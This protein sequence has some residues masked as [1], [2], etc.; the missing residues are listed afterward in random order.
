MLQNIAFNQKAFYTPS[1]HKARM[2]I[3]VLLIATFH[4]ISCVKVHTDDY[5]EGYLYSQTEDGLVAL[6]NA[7]AE[8]LSEDGEL[9]ET[10]TVP[11]GRQNNFLSIPLQE[12]WLNSPVSLRIGGPNNASILWQG[13]APSTNAMWLPGALFAIEDS[14][15]YT[16]LSSFAE[17]T[18]TEITGNIHL[19]GEPYF[20]EEWT[21]V[22]ISLTDNE[23][24]TYTVY[25]FSQL[26]TGLISTN[27]E[28][29][30]DWFFAWNLPAE[31][32]TLSITTDQGHEKRL[33]YFPNEGDILSALYVTLPTEEP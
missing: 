29:K 28:Q 15:L 18:D 13:T 20:P 3:Y 1:T 16:F 7:E 11:S 33:Q 12:D 21:G 32:L 9:L 4:H 8:L 25:S 6:N 26:D 2:S 19:W 10:G 17:A 5:W 31:P 23:Q 14:Y 30:I 22:S 27:I 24:Q